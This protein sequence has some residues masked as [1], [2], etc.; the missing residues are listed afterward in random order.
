MRDALPEPSPP[1]LPPPTVG[2]RLAFG[3]TAVVENTKFQVYEFF[4]IFYYAQVLGLR[5]ALA[6]LAV[7]IAMLADALLDPLIGSYSDSHR[8]PLG[9]RHT[10]MFLAIV[11]TAI[12]V[13]LLFDAPAGLGQGG[14]FAWM[15]AFCIAARLAGSFYSVPAAAIAAELTQDATLRA[16][17]GI[18]RQAVTSALQ[19][20]LTWL[21]FH[22]AFVATPL[23]PRGQENP[24]N[25]PR[26]ALVVVAVLM[27]AA[28]FGAAGTWR[29]IRAFERARVAPQP[30]RF[31]V[32]A[33]LRATWRA[34]ADQRNFRAVFLGLLFAGAM[35][36]YFRALNLHLGTYFWELS[37]A[38][39][40]N[41]LMSIQVATFVAAI[42]SRLVI[43]RLEPKTLYVAGVATLLLAY[44]LPPLLRLLDLLP[45]NGSEALVRVLYL[46][47]LFA[48]AGTGLIMTTSLVMLAETADEYA[49]Q[50]R[51]SRTG[52][53]LAFLPLGNKLA[54]GGGKL[55]AGIVVQWV[56]LPVG[57]EARLVDPAAVDGLGLA[58]IAFTVVAGTVA[59]VFYAGYSLPRARHAEILRGL[60]ALRTRD[61]GSAS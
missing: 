8:G 40:G 27:L 46:A 60:E 25:Y 49:L 13:W 11:P 44:V 48:G 36:S 17:L 21:V 29:P 34:L 57:H 1:R 6:G 53:L 2:A 31:S 39:T 43:G 5:G 19:L 9:R 58:A 38:Q 41:W 7:A 51:E 42:A 59:L 52:M 15:L 24:D 18:W 50:Q 47:N 28:L 12:F 14:L 4:L 10:L 37:T 22:Y 3:L 26:F 45:P 16:E 56:A 20:G 55:L 61:V 23:L 30:A 33:S 54:S 32:T 35:G